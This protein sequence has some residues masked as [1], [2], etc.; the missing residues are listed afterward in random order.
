MSNE[1][2]EHHCEHIPDS[3]PAV[4]VL[5]HLTRS[6][7]C[8]TNDKG[9][10]A[11]ISLHQTTIKHSTIAAKKYG[12]HGCQ[13]W[14]YFGSYGHHVAQ[15]IAVIDPAT[16]SLTYFHCLAAGTCIRQFSPRLGLCGHCRWWSAWAHVGHASPI[17]PS[18]QNFTHTIHQVWFLSFF[19]L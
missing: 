8:A 13:F 15:R 10:I 2:S 11:V 14:L 9:L 5:R 1:I 18:V 3:L 19:S 7:Y 4:K 17:M 6:S 16:K 12:A